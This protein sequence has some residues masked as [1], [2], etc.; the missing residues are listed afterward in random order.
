MFIWSIIFGYY[1]ASITCVINYHTL[2]F[3]YHFLMLRNRSIKWTK[4][5]LKP[6]FFLII[7]CLT[8]PTQFLFSTTPE[9]FWEFEQSESS[10][11]AGKIQGYST[12]WEK[13]LKASKFALGIV[14]EGYKIP[15][16]SEPP[17]FFAKNNTSSLKNQAFVRESIE[18]LLE[19]GCI[20]KVTE[21]PYCINP[22]T[23]AERN[24]KLRKTAFCAFI[25]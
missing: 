9:R 5:K 25:W 19:N 7:T 13:E 18:K 12:F 8:S 17:A 14:R 4:V 6:L 20:E 2:F 22:L 1:I 24:S 15:F 11:V 3:F 21:P 16:E 10:S 23:V